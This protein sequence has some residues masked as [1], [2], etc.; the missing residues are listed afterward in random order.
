MQPIKDSGDFMLDIGDVIYASQYSSTTS[1]YTIDRVTDTTA[2]AGRSKFRR[3]TQGRHV[4]ESPKQTWGASYEIESPELKAAYQRA[5]MVGKLK[6]ILWSKLPDADLSA[7]WE[8]VK[9]HY[10]KQKAAQPRTG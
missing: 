7:V 10:D 8:I 2:F 3:R 5:L 6:G 4:Q 9:E 1:K